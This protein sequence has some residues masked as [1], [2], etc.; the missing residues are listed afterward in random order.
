[1]DDV[2]RPDIGVDSIAMGTFAPDASRARI[3][4]TLHV[5][6]WIGDVRFSFD[7]PTRAGTEKVAEVSVAV[8][9]LVRALERVAAERMGLG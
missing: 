4:A 5:A 7:L 3:T 2:S 8:E 1:M 9:L 6:G